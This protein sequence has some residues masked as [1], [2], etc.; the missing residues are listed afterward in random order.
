MT[1]LTF[2][3]LFLAML[4][5]CGAELTAPAD[6]SLPT[7]FD[8]TPP[9][10]SSL[11]GVR[12]Y[13][14]DAGVCMVMGENDLTESLIEDKR[15]LIGCPKHE[16]GAIGDRKIEGARVVAYQGHWALLSLQQP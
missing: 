14:I 8:Y 10:D 1:R 11:I 12:P 3:Y 16:M 15:L 5:G 7:R 4:A 6:P 9:E 13:P 2:A